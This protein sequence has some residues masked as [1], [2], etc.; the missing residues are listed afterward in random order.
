MLGI[1]I[2][3]LTNNNNGGVLVYLE[4]TTEL[5][6]FRDLTMKEQLNKINTVLIYRKLDELTDCFFVVYAP[7]LGKNGSIDG[8]VEVDIYNYTTNPKSLTRENIEGVFVDLAS[9]N[10]KTLKEFEDLSENNKLELIKGEDDT[11]YRGFDNLTKC[12]L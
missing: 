11:V 1:G 12:F 2:M 10:V 4:S 9:I 3:S 6:N 8:R 7:I 5:R